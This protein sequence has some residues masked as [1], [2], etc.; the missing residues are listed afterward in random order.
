MCGRF[1]NYLPYVPESE[2]R[3]LFRL[4]PQLELPL[5]PPLKRRYNIAPRDEVAAVRL[6]PRTGEREL[7]T[8]LWS[9]VPRWTPDARDFLKKFATFN[10]KS[11][12]AAERASYKTPLRKQRCLI[13]ANGFFEW[14]DE[15]GRGKV[16]HFIRVRDEELF[17]FAGLYDVWESRDRAERIESCTILLTEPND[18]VRP[19]HGNAMPVI[20]RP[21]D[22]D[23]WL[24]PKLTDP[25]DLTHLLK[26]YPAA[27]MYAYPVS[28]AVG[29]VRNDDPRCV[30]PR[31]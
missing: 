23:D 25:A 27:R 17:A 16:P 31:K 8:L 22:Y 21:A 9:L 14:K 13:L 7:V 30:E 2:F 18:V 5:E 29:N 15:G 3:R 26:P 6:S 12:T 20:L 4:P 24:D 11:E 28:A 1:A 10:A 19:I